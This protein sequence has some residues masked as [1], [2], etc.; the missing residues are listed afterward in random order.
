M[1]LA[2]LYG[3]SNATAAA[4]HLQ[5]ANGMRSGILD[6]MWNPSKLAFY[7][8]NLTSN[9]RN[10][11]FTAATFY[12]VWNDII[13][14]EVLASQSNAF[15]YFSAVNMVMNKYNGTFP[16]TFLDYTGLQW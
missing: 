2:E 7:D 6:L 8:F 14:N 16:V 15:G 12:P 1:L 9:S 3:N 4:N 11:I 5:I 10:S 13:P